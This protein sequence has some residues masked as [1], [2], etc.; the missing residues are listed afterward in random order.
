MNNACRTWQSTLP[1]TNPNPHTQRG[2]WPGSR[3]QCRERGTPWSQYK[4]S[5]SGT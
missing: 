1:T 5:A 2:S 4:S 3:R